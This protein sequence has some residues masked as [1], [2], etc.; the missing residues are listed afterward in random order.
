MTLNIRKQEKPIV[1]RVSILL[2][3][4]SKVG[5]THLAAQFPKPLVVSCEPHGTDFLMDVDILD[6]NSL[7]ELV[8]A[9]NQIKATDYTT[10]VLDGIT[11]LINREAAGVAAGDGGRQR[12]GQQVYGEITRKFNGAM[13]AALSSN[14]II[15]AT[16]H[17]RGTA[18]SGET[19]KVGS[20]EF[21]KM[22]VAP[23]LNPALADDI[24]HHFSIVCYC[25]AGATHPQMITKPT[26]DGKRVIRAGDRTGVLPNPMQ[27]NAQQ[28]F[29]ILKKLATDNKETSNGKV[30]GKDA[31]VAAQIEGAK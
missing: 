26:D 3:G 10:V 13:M 27:M 25:Y 5:K 17:S 1:T 31:S 28:M 14:K 20:D 23:D 18:I 9:M 30:S 7:Q 19:Y 29:A 2:Y 24:V 21:P 12:H 8:V 15:V 22:Q 11:S 16:G 6:V 4:E